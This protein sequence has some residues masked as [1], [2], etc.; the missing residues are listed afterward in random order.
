MLIRRAGSRPT[1]IT[2]NRSRSIYETL[3]VLIIFRPCLPCGNDRALFSLKAQAMYAIAQQMVQTSGTKG[4][5]KGTPGYPPGAFPAS[6]LPFDQSILSRSPFNALME[7]AV[8][9]YLPPSNSPPAS[10]GT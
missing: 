1:T 3:L 8:A 7:Q 6:N 4:P 9:P 10:R 2:G 5:T